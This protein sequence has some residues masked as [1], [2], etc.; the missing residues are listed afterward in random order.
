MYLLLVFYGCHNKLP[1]TK[2]LFYCSIGQKSDVGLTVLKSK[3]SVFLSGGSREES[4]SLVFSASSGC[5]HS[6]AHCP[7]PFTLYHSD[8]DSSASFF[9]LWG[10]LRLL[11]THLDNPEKSP[12]F[13]ADW[14]ATL[15]LSAIL[16]HSPCH[17]LTI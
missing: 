6:L 15:T 3:S 12:Y 5:L 7:L 1:Y 4:V 13:K 10:T 9:H 14:L 16:I 2:L 8:T 11:W 17:I